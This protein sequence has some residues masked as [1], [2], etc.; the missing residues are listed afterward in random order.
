MKLF[1]SFNEIKSEYVYERIYYILEYIKP[2]SFIEFHDYKRMHLMNRN[3]IEFYIRNSYQQGYYEGLDIDENS[4]KAFRYA[5]NCLN[6]VKMEYDVKINRTVKTFQIYSDL[7][8]ICCLVPSMKSIKRMDLI[9]K[10]IFD[11]HLLIKNIF[12]DGQLEKS[13]YSAPAVAFQTNTFRNLTDDKYKY[14]DYVVIER[15]L[16]K[17]R[18]KEIVFHS[19][20]YYPAMVEPWSSGLL[21]PSV[22]QLKYFDL[23]YS[24]INKLMFIYE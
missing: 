16:Y 19:S 1:K 3:P 6:Q 21:E 7:D 8:Q 24:Q 14:K 13:Y 9:P 17:N 23:S 22:N 20:K 10:D 12:I 4:I 18:I 5:Y 11:S 2:E 15:N